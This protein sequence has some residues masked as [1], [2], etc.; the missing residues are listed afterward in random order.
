MLGVRKF[1]VPTAAIALFALPGQVRAAEYTWRSDQNNG[2]GDWTNTNNWNDGNIFVSG[3]ANDLRMSNGND[4]WTNGPVDIITNVPPTLTARYL[5]L[6]GR[7]DGGDTTV[8]V[9]TS[10]TTLTLNNNNNSGGTCEISLNGYNNGNSKLAFIVP[11]NITL[12]SNLTFRNNS[13]SYTSTNIFTGNIGESTAGRT[14]TKNDAN[15]VTLRGTN[16][17]SGGTILRGGTMWING[18]RALG[19]VPALFD[20]DNI[21]FDGGALKREDGGGF[22]LAATRGIEIQGGG[23]EIGGY[24]Q[25]SVPGVIKGTGVFTKSGSLTLTLQANNSY[26]GN[27]T[28]SGGILALGA[29]GSIANSSKVTL[30]P[31]GVLHTSAKPS[32][33]VPATQEYTFHVDGNGPGSSGLIQAAEL[34]ITNAHVVITADSTLNDRVY[35]L[36]NYTKLTGSAFATVTDPLPNGYTIDYA[37]NGGTQIALVSPNTAWEYTWRADQNNGP[38]DWNNAANWNDGNIFVSGIGNN[39]LMSG[40]NDDWTNGAVDIVNNVPPTLTTKKFT[41]QGRADGGDTTVTVGTSGTTLTLNNNNNSGGTCEISLNGYNNGNSKLAF[42]VP[43]NITL[44]SNLTFR[45]NSDAYTSTNIF[46]G[47]IGESTVGRTLTKNDANQVTLRGTNSYSGGTILRGGT[48]WI[49]GDRA[50]GAVPALFDDDNIRFDGGALKREDGGGFDLAATRGI[51]IQGGGGEMGG[52]GDMNVLGLIKGSGALTKSGGSTLS[53]RANNPY[54]GNISITGGTLEVQNTGKL[55]GGYYNGT[56]AISEGTTFRYGGGDGEA[57]TMNGVISGVGEVIKEGSGTLILS[58]TNTYSGPTNVNGGLLVLAA[59]GSINNSASVTLMPGAQLDTYEV[60][61]YTIPATQNCTFHLNGDGAGSCGWIRAGYLNIGDANVSLIVDVALDDAVYLLANYSTLGGTIR[62]FA[63][64][65]GLP[66]GYFIDYAYNGGTQ[67][68]LVAGTAPP[69]TYASW[70]TENGIDGQPAYGDFDKDGVDNAVE[71]VLGGLPATRMDAGL[72]PTLARVTNPAGV[73][74]GNYLEFTYRRTAL[75]AAAGV[76]T[77]CQ[78]NTDLGPTWNTAQDGEAGVVVLVDYDYVPYGTATDR[79][80]VY[81]P[82]GTHAKLFGR[83]HV[84]VP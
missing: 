59:S 78:Y 51:E 68:A 72:M 66:D 32:F 7:A 70:A 74:A 17:Y 8:T 26:S 43:I 63:S 27:I 67:I 40:G 23:G 25:M 29:S 37:Y 77:T 33:A 42:I 44:F 14:L 58:G 62:K 9:G 73:P 6:Q 5:A 21:K 69:P 15:Q 56:V 84:T 2:P 4:D 35:V 52:Y 64:V 79:V 76:S 28:V 16:S 30:R 19:A 48:M 24:G 31:G 82:R 47:N 61:N 83:L 34:D 65:T 75:S 71:M 49:N 45:N 12:F 46:T 55:Q 20:D 38:G 57:Q 11:I 41:L 36:A 1:A 81:V 3:V 22:N 18:D 10:G 54:S 13:D 60:A 39:L 50:L 53:L 80:R